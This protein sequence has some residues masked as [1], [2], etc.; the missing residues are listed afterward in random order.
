[1]GQ[2]SVC[3]KLNGGRGIFL[4]MCH[5]ERCQ[6]QF[7]HHFSTNDEDEDGANYEYIQSIRIA[8]DKSEEK[9]R[10][11]AEAKAEKERQQQLRNLPLPPST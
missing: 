8:R 4:V 2:E 6:G 5:E 3:G 11:K 7:T 1:M 9:A 10:A